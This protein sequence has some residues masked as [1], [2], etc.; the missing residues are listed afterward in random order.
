M[1]QRKGQVRKA[2]KMGGM[3][4]KNSQEKEKEK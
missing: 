2:S 1:T 4:G 3:N